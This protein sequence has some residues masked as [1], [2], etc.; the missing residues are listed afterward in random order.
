MIRLIAVFVA[1]VSVGMNLLLAPASG[2]AQE[3]AAD[4]AGADN[5][6][7]EIKVHASI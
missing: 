1:L 7:I 3:V 2:A 4:C 6:C 5:G